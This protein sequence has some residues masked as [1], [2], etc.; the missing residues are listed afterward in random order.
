[1]ATKVGVQT[2][3]GQPDHR[4]ANNAIDSVLANAAYD[5][6]RLRLKATT[7]K[8]KRQADL[9]GAR[10]TARADRYTKGVS[11][12]TGLNQ[13]M[14]YQNKQATAAAERWTQAQKRNQQQWQDDFN[15]KAK[16][17]DLKGKQR[18]KAWNE[19]YER[20]A[21]RLP[22]WGVIQNLQATGKANAATYGRQSSALAGD[23]AKYEAMVKRQ[24]QAYNRYARSIKA[25]NRHSKFVRYQPA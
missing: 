3:S 18:T 24:K 12:L 20:Q 19:Y 7:R 10:V 5:D 16:Y 15:A 2:R 4:G 22:E 17:A 23:R 14:Q 8:T 21:K 25:Y 9:V 6:K 11:A 13:T 1:M